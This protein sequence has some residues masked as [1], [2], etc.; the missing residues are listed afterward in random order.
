MSWVKKLGGRLPDLADVVRRFPIA[1]LIM[2]VFTLWLI[3]EPFSGRMPEDEGYIFG[4]FILCGY[5]AVIMGLIS[6]A[7]GWKRPKGLMLG[8]SIG[9][10]TFL[11]CYLARHLDFNVPMA[12]AAA[13]VFLGNAAAFRHSRHD[14]HVWN[15]TQK[16]WT[17]AI[18]AAVGSGIFALG[19]IAIS[20][21]MKSLFGV[22]IETLTFEVLMP[23]GLA[24]LAPVYWLG[25]LPRYGDVEDVSEIS[26][27]ARILSFLGTWMLAPLVIIYS[28]IILAYGAKVLV[29]WELPKGEIATLVTPFLGVGMLVWL[30]LEPK[31][32]KESGFVKF[33]RRVWH[34][35][36]LV[37]AILLAIAVF[38]R[39][40][41][42]GFTT[43]RFL[44][45]LVS[46]WAFAQSLWFMVRAETKRDIRVPTGIAAVLL[47]FGAFVAEP[48]SLEN[49]FRRGKAAKVAW[50]DYNGNTQAGKA[51]LG[52]L[53]FLLK[54]QDEKRFNKLL[55][56][57]KM[58]LNRR[59]PDF[60][61]L[62]KNL[63][64]DRV[65]NEKYYRRVSFSVASK[66]PI[67]L[68][69]NS[70][71][72]IMPS[73]SLSGEIQT[74]KGFISSQYGALVVLSVEDEIY[75]LN[76]ERLFS[77]L[78]LVG[79]DDR[80]VNTIVPL[81]PVQSRSGRSA[82]LAVFSGELLYEGNDLGGGSIEL[83]LIVP[84]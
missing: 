7:R 28:L 67:S 51:Y 46:I 34:W 57:T 62:V 26:F 36:M 40:R 12:I 60:A 11:V 9:L 35:V 48:I 10:P 55:P 47:L 64:L 42:Y 41:E 50:T 54:H 38:V 1:V 29:Q 49:Q 44:L 32:L 66:Q 21:A 72:F 75:R 68:A 19:M 43:E 61:T 73:I 8:I 53:E 69:N 16:L 71:L 31:V 39:I 81:L 58:P 78:E 33:Y 27:E 3:F 4:G 5:I 45:M 17:G 52:S 23:I 6:E 83:A 30:M 76:F 80:R 22:D 18:F 2:G 77:N 82:I 63:E 70:K 25:T 79:P 84:N 59:G 65:N 37:A 56:N 74:P 24:F 15:F 14:S 13:I 20:Q